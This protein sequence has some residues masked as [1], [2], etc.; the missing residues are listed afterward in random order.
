[1]Y[2]FIFQS[3]NFEV[4][5]VRLSECPILRHLMSQAVYLGNFNQYCR[6]FEQYWEGKRSQIN[7]KGTSNLKK[8]QFPL[9]VFNFYFQMHMI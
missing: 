8:H 9:Y 3:F 2:Q 4:L 5:S 1:M 7:I 6:Y